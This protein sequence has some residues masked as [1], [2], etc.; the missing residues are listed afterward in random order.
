MEDGSPA[1]WPADQ[2]NSLLKA[3][4]FVDVGCFLMISQGDTE[5]IPGEKPQKR[6]VQQPA[7]FPGQQMIHIHVEIAGIGLTGPQVPVCD[8]K[9]IHEGD[10]GRFAR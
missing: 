10:P 5:R 6:F 9:S 1:G 8:L 2:V 4:L 3:V 7:V